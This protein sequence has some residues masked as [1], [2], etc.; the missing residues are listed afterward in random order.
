MAKEKQPNKKQDEQK[1]FSNRKPLLLKG[2]CAI[3]H[4]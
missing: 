4:D 2:D 1:S 3:N